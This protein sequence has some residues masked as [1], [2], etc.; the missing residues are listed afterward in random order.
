MKAISTN[1]KLNFSK[2]AIVSF[3]STDVKSNNFIYT[4][5]GIGVFTQTGF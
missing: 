4:Q 2:K 1:S 3:E 5:T